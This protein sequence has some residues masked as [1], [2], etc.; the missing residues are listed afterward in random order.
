MRFQPLAL[1]LAA[2]AAPTL[3]QT[4]ERVVP[5]TSNRLPVKY[6]SIVVTP[7]IMLPERRT[8]LLLLLSRISQSMLT[9]PQ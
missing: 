1:S 7:G 5:S 9:H 6:G 2:L 8:S 4:P 3:G